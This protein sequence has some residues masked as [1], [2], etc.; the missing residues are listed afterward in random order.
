MARDENYKT[1]KKVESNK[2]PDSVK[3]Q[4][5]YLRTQKKMSLRE[6]AE[7]TNSNVN[8]IAAHL[9]K[10]GIRQKRRELIEGRHEQW[11]E[12]RLE[13]VSIAKIAQKFHVR[14][15]TLYRF[16]S[17]NE[18]LLQQRKR[19]K[20]IEPDPEGLIFVNGYWLQEDEARRY[21]AIHAAKVYLGNEEEHS[22]KKIEDTIKRLGLWDEDLWAEP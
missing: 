14:Q 4:W 20:K 2:I 16:F 21:M 17:K 13:G 5:I 22:W 6:I 7:A 12:M 19:P 9:C 1:Q 3:E 11:I 10:K 18:I 15:G 8:T